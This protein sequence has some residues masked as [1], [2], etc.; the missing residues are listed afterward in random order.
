MISKEI[1][2]NNHLDLLANLNSDDKI[3][4]TD[5]DFVNELALKRALS[6]ASKA[7]NSLDTVYERI[8]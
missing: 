6:R 8:T 2:M 4:N 5:R 7:P 1:E 3:D